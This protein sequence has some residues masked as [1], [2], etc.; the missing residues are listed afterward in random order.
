[1]VQGKEVSASQLLCSY[2]NPTL[3]LETSQLAHN[4]SIN[5]LGTG[6]KSMEQTVCDLI[7]TGKNHIVALVDTKEGATVSILVPEGFGGQAH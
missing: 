3:A 7:Y 2:L 6:V 4:Q 5:K 1:M